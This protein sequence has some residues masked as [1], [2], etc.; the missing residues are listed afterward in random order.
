MV[1]V[2]DV[3][4]YKQ[5]RCP[6]EKKLVYSNHNAHGYGCLGRPN[7]NIGGLISSVGARRRNSRERR[8]GGTGRESVIGRDVG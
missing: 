5:M 2:R 4:R 1:R 8:S 7:R 3:P 6:Q